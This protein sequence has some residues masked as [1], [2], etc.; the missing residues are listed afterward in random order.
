MLAKAKRDRDS[1]VSALD[2]QDEPRAREAL[3][4][5][6]VTAYHLREWAREGRP[7]LPD[8]LNSSEAIAACRDLANAS[9]HVELVRLKRPPKVQAVVVSVAGGSSPVAPTKWRLKVQLSGRRIGVEELASEALQ[10][11]DDYFR[12]HSIT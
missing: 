1:L 5:F 4:N 10:D 2:L 7:S 9:K 11:W 3:F 12:K 6:V 8:P